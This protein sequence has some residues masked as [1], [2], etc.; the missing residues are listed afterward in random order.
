VLKYGISENKKGNVFPIWGTCLGMQLLAY[1]TSGYDAKAIAPVRGE[2]ATRNTLSIQS[3]N[4]L[5]TGLSSDL[6]NRLQS[7][8]G[9]LYFNHHYA[10]TKQYYDNSP[11]LR[12][13]WNVEAYTTTSYSEEFLSVFKAKDYPFYGVQFHPE[14]NLFEWKVYADRSDSGAEIVQILSNRFVEQARQ[15]KGS[16]SNDQ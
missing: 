9:V 8:V 16:F 10:V 7:G 6:L 1:L 4:T 12:A 13:F 14:K 2:V 11:L 15:S 3:Q 5:F